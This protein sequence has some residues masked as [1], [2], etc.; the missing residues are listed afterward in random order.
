LHSLLTPRI[1]H[2]QANIAEERQAAAELEDLVMH[3][4]LT[5]L[6]AAVF[7]VES[8]PSRPDGFALIDAVTTVH[9]GSKA[10]LLFSQCGHGRV[11][12][13]RGCR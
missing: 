1:K 7:V 8:F 11:P 3:R 10:L 6:Q 2:S 12:R 5:P 4:A 9:G 13:E